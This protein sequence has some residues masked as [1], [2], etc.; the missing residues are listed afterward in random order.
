MMSPG[1]IRFRLT[2]WYAGVLAGILILF[3][4][5]TY[6]GVSH[7]LRRNLHESVVK[8]AQE[9][10][11]IVRENANEKDE[12]A[13][14]REVGEHFSPE[15]N[16]RAIR[17]VN[18]KGNTIYSS[19][20]EVFPAWNASATADQ[21]Y[22]ITNR[23]A[24]QEYLIRTQPVVADSGK[25]YFVQV[26][27]SLHRN[28]EI[29]EQLLGVLALAL[30]LATAIAV[31]GGFLLIRSSLRPLDNMAMRA[32]KIT[33]RSL[34][35]RMPV[36]DTGDELQQLS[37]SLNRM[38]ERLEEAFHHI[39]R[40]SADASHELRTPLTIMR[41]ELET[42]VQNPKIEADVR[43]T[44]GAV[45]EE[46]VRLSKIVDQLLTMSR[47]DAGE[48]FLEVSSFDFS[49]LV[50]TTV[51][52]IR[53]LAEEK[54]LAL[55]VDAAAEV[56]VE[57]DQSR[58]QQVVVNLL[59]NAIKYTP[60]GGLIRVSVHGEPGKA[61]LTITD[62]GIGISEEGQA[63]IFERFYRTDKA[64]SRELGGIGLGLSIVKS[65]GAAH[66]GRVSVQSAEGRGS[67]F[68]FEIPRLAGKEPKSVP[69]NTA[70]LSSTKASETS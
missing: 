64:R 50:R 70:I 60:E 55:K 3:S 37:I 10:G 43:D 21:A 56:Q 15:S 25:K 40:F 32:Q 63:H 47:L 8:D 6:V 24:G 7:F 26:A 45:L 4:I 39:S 14:G 36:S 33:S 65:I 59:D 13:V 16:E 61:V 62:T 38:I 66:G 9:I 52:Y 5:A 17:V 18:A 49:E 31:T 67:T 58:L 54:K 1:S 42:A 34:H 51:E 46:T 28:E 29:L 30:L 44:F 48:A 69:E 2:V 23:A 22:D 20:G 27:A 35:E 19:G 12:S 57:G 41:G 11:S 53:L 68:R